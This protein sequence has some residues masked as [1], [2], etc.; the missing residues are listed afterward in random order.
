MIGKISNI[1]QK[2][3]KGQKR[4]YKNV[5]LNF[6]GNFWNILVSSC[7]FFILFIWG[8]QLWF[9]NSMWVYHCML[10]VHRVHGQWPSVLEPEQHGDTS[11]KS[12][13]LNGILNLFS[14][15]T[16]GI[17]LP[18]KRDKEEFILKISASDIA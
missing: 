4:F 11:L 8:V 15:L 1:S 9:M 6:G 16:Q 7:T 14:A 18:S 13:T 2:R 10:G 5:Q 3:K 12:L 17:P